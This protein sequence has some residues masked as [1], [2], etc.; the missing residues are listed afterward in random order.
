[1]IKEGWNITVQSQ[2]KYKWT[3]MS[4]RVNYI[5]LSVSDDGVKNGT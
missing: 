5:K 1:M 2:I 4:C 3:K